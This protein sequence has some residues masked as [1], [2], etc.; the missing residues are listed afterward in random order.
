MGEI[1]GAQVLSCCKLLQIRNDLDRQSASKRKDC[2]KLF[3]RLGVDR[4][5]VRLPANCSQ[6]SDA[7]ATFLYGDVQWGIAVDI[8]G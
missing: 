7:I 6:L 2:R 8:L 5:R 4:F 1:M 3:G